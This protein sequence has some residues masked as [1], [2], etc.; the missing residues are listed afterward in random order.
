MFIRSNRVIRSY[1]NN[2]EC[3]VRVTFVDENRLQYR[4]DREMDGKSFLRSRVGTILQEGLDVAGTHLEF[5]AYSQSALR[6]SSVWFVRPF[7]GRN[8]GLVNAASIIESLGTFHEVPYDRYLAYCP[9]RYGARVSQAFTATDQSIQVEAEEI[10]IKPDIERDGWNFTDGV[11][12]ISPELAESI[13]RALYHKR[14]RRR[15]PVA[16][17]TTFQIRLQ[18]VG[19]SSLLSISILNYC[20]V[21]KGCSALTTRFVV[22]LSSSAPV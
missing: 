1:P 21:R 10:E 19:I 3:F 11:G 2:T 22:E 4:F 6:E 13:C 9:A 15:K 20:R 12:T 8:G 18:V 7:I 16:E 17:P 5:L 14:K